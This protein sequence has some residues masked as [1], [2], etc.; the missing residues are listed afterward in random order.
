MGGLTPGT[1]TD[2]D[3]LDVGAPGDHYLGFG[4][5]K[6]ADGIFADEEQVGATFPDTNVSMI[7]CDSPCPLPCLIH[8]SS[9]IVWRLEGCMKGCMTGCIIRY[10]PLQIVFQW[11]WQSLSDGGGYI[12]CADVKI[13]LTEEPCGAIVERIEGDISSRVVRAA[14]GRLSA[15]RVFLCK[16]VMYGAFVWARRAL[17]HQKRRF[18]ARAGAAGVQRRRRPRRRWRQGHRGDGGPGGRH[19]ALARRCP[20]PPA[21]EKDAMLAQKLG[22]LQPYITVFPQECMGQLASFGP[23]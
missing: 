6:T 17:K 20:L 21:G 15:L 10:C 16:S 3:G 14:Q 12:G 5:P 9:R 13:S 19:R 7:K 2:Q 8:R 23:T 18:P 11:M 1:L 22:Q 4:V